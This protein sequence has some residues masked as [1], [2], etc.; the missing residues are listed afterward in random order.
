MIVQ[1]INEQLQYNI[2]NTLQLMFH[3]LKIIAD[4]LIYNY[5]HKHFINNREPTVCQTIDKYEL[6]QKFNYLC[7]RIPEWVIVRQLTQYKWHHTFPY[8]FILIT[9][10]HNI[11]NTVWQYCIQTKSRV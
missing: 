3:L 5:I 6:L 10:G 8:K 11:D 4:I 2:N 9:K 1:L 7:F